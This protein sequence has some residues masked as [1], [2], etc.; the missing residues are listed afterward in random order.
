MNEKANHLCVLL[1][2][3]LPPAAKGWRERALLVAG[4]GAGG[5][6]EERC[7]AFTNEFAAAARWLGKGEI[8]PTEADRE[9]LESA[10]I[11]FPHGL[12]LDE[13]GRIAML[14]TLSAHA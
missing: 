13:L 4:P 5:T 14:V 6:L 11:S 3:R 10:G 1:D 12:P 2:R 7:S 8:D 9:G